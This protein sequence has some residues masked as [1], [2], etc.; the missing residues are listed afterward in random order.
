MKDFCVCVGGGRMC[1][2]NKMCRKKKM[3]EGERLGRVRSL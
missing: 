3:Q 2:K 1:R